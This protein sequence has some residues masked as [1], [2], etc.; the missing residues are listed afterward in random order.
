MKSYIT[1]VIKISTFDSS[2]SA[3]ENV[4]SMPDYIYANESLNNVSFKDYM[5]QRATSTKV[6][7]ILQFK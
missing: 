3:T 1:P 4:L 6:Q 5:S 2:V 7:N